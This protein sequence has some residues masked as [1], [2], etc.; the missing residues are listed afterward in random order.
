MVTT[1]KRFPHLVNATKYGVGLLVTLAGLVGREENFDSPWLALLYFNTVYSFLW[2]ITM[3]W[4][5][6]RSPNTLLCLPY[7]WPLGLR[8]H[9]LFSSSW[10][11][12]AAASADLGLRFFYSYTLVPDASQLYPMVYTS[13]N[14]IAGG[15]ELCRRF[16]WS[17]FKLENV[18]LH[19]FNESGYQLPRGEV[20][21]R[22][23][24]NKAEEAEKRQKVLAQQRVLIGVEVAAFFAVVVVLSVVVAGV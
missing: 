8:Q 12:F 10:V 24:V 9:R 11:Y 3:D 7:G 23:D 17:I 1:G 20:V 5:L 4:A 14:R 15:L 16:I 19:A 18:Q 21:A 6:I 2:D 22:T 13:F